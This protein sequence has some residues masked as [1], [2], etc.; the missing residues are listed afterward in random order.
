MWSCTRFPDCRGAI[1]ISPSTDTEA[2]AD[3]WPS[4]PADRRAAHAQYQFERERAKR[5]LKLRALLPLLVGA[6]VLAMAMSF[7]AFLSF[8]VGIASVAAVIFG[9]LFAVA[10]SRLPLDSLIWLKGFEGE[11][12]T[13]AYLEPLLRQGF[14]LLHNRQLP[15]RNADVDHIAI[16]PSGVFT[17]E[18]KNWRGRLDVTFNRLS[19]GDNDRTW[20]VEQVY[21]EAIAV[22]IALGEVLNER[23]I[24]VRP[25]LC[26]LGGVPRLGAKSVSG[27]TITDGKDLAS[28]LVGRPQ[29]LSAD[30]V[31]RL[32]GLADERLK[33]TY[34]WERS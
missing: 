5:R 21:R 16:G 24:T 7:F 12:R 23:R 20:V 9:M 30:D 4:R 25:I 15:G 29:I 13:A 3:D 26:A 2:A 17:I 32:A 19:V 1:N 14:V 10:I 8:G 18:T 27:V 22:Q 11:S 34:T 28:L 31:Q 33:P 6:G